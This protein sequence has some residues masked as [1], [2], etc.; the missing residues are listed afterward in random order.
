[1]TQF[2]DSCISLACLAAIKTHSGGCCTPQ[3]SGAERPQHDRHGSDASFDTH[4]VTGRKPFD[5]ART[6]KYH[7]YRK[8]LSPLSGSIYETAAK[9][10]SRSN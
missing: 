7:R 6:V 2:S 5:R 9:A 3:V 10:K 8:I 1:V 4:T